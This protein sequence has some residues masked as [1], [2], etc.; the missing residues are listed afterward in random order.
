VTRS[1]LLA[2]IKKCL[3]LAASATEHEAAAALGMAR[4]L[5]DEYG[6]DQI[7]LDL[8]DVA[9]ADARGSGNS[10]PA[11]WES[12]LVSAVERALT[13]EVI[14][15]PH[16]GWRFI[17]LAPAPEIASYAFL[18]LFRQLKKARAEYIGTELRRCTVARKRKRADVFCEG[19]ASAVYRKIAA[20]NPNRELHPFVRAFLA[21]RY[22]RLDQVEARAAALTG[23]VAARDRGNGYDAGRSVSLHRGVDQNAPAALLGRD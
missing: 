14:L 4:K 15:I 21:E 19:W 1:D 20:L 10:V 9:E 17:G 5:M 6:V 16:S 13:V 11:E 22:P 8:A 2:K 7:E 12:Y 18:V 23:A 3:A